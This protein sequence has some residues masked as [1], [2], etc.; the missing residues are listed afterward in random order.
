MHD[1]YNGAKLPP[2][3]AL[4]YLGDAYHSLY[5][6]NMLVRRGVGKSKE[7]NLFSLEY[8][9][10]ERQ[11]RMYE[12]IKPYL[13]EDELLLSRRAYNSTHLNPPKRAKIKDYRSATAFEAVLGM[14]YYI[15]D[16]Q[17][18]LELLDIAHGGIQNDTED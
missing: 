9:T 6:R 5:V 16:T 11:A 3:L 18:L 4:S 8:V 14:L 7:L 12:L 13:T 15:N 10:A 2:V 17:R 1:N